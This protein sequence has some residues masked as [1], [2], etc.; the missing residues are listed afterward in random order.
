MI[1]A[2]VGDAT[3]G[4]S[5]PA[6]AEIAQPAENMTN[7]P[8]TPAEA[9]I[10]FLYK[11]RIV[12]GVYKVNS[13]TVYGFNFE[14]EKHLQLFFWSIRYYQPRVIHRIYISVHL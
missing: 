2:Q 3:D 11:K 10:T 4:Q 12:F 8:F 6:D 14:T 7:G 13:S 1:F 9:E 5:T